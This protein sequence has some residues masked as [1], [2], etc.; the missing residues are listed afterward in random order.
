LSVVHALRSQTWA[1]WLAISL[2]VTSRLYAGD[3]FQF[4]VLA[5]TGQAGLMG[6]QGAPSINDKGKVAFVGHDDLSDGIWIADVGTPKKITPVL[7]GI[8]IQPAI[9][10]NNIGKVV[11]RTVTQ[12]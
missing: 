3:G 7:S 6:I 11:S 12:G 8:T 9:Q 2:A 1:F 10:M 4:E 5:K